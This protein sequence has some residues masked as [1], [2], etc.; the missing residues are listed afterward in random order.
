MNKLLLVPT[1]LCLAFHTP[2]GAQVV[3]V[4]PTSRIVFKCT[5]EGEVVYSDEPCMGA[6]VLNIQPTRGMNKSSG[7]EMTGQDVLIERNHEAFVQA[8][9]PVTGMNDQQFDVAKRRVNMSGPQKAECVGLDGDIAAGEAQE[10]VAAKDALMG[11]QSRLLTMRKR[12]R[13]LGC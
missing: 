4:P 2:I 6:Q 13:G 5:V 10:R 11:V 1:L 12:Y 8:I 9:Q 3:K 7:K